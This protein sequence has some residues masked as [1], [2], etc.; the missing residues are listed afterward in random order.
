MVLLEI[1]VV[2]IVM[3]GGGRYSG[4]VP[5]GSLRPN[6]IFPSVHC[7]VCAVV[8]NASSCFQCRA[9]VNVGELSWCT[10]ENPLAP[11]LPSMVRKDKWC[12]TFDMLYCIHDDS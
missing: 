9:S 4:L 12:H 3:R 10:S 8:S 11:T 5:E 1:K 6:V 2:Y 7:F